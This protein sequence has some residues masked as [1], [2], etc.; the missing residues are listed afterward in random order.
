MKREEPAVQPLA[1]CL[2]YAYRHL[3]ARLAKLFDAPS[4]HF[5]EGVYA[6]HDDTPHPLADN[7][8]GA[9][10]RLPVVRTG[11]EADIH[12]GFLQQSFIFRG[13]RSESVHL[14]VPLAAPHM[15][16]LADDTSVGNDHRPHH[17][18][19]A[20][21]HPSAGC[22]LQAAAHIQFVSLSLFHIR[23]VNDGSAILL[24]SQWSGC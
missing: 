4:L 2:Q 6:A 21:L 3:D 17:R 10:R 16:A 15:I 12:R 20:R 19:G 23:S 7:Q 9:R 24:C 13:D 5:G 18:I 22:Q 14:G 1:F 11:F 8:V